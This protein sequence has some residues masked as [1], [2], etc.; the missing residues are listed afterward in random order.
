MF[1]LGTKDD[2]VGPRLWGRRTGEGRSLP[3]LS[4]PEQA[5]ASRPDSHGPS[6]GEVADLYGEDGVRQSGQEKLAMLAGH[7]RMSE[8][9][10]H[11]LGLSLDGEQVLGGEG[12][13][14]AVGSRQDGLGLGK[15]FGGHVVVHVS[16]MDPP[17]RDCK[18][19]LLGCFTYRRTDQIRPP[20]LRTGRRTGSFGVRSYVTSS[21][22]NRSG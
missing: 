5:A 1:H 17:L 15:L 4:A 2:P 13:D 18:D 3:D 20:S 7:G 16:I 9:G 21:D 19:F 11:E 10:K 6:P 14:S 8:L 12:P 22:E